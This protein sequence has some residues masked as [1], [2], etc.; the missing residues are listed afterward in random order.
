MFFALQL[1]SSNGS[2]TVQQFIF[3]FPEYLASNIVSLY[4]IQLPFQMIFMFVQMAVCAIF[5]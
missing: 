3:V 1:S 2:N 5:C 4:D